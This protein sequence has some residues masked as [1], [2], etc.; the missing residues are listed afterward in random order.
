MCRA[1]LARPTRVRYQKGETY[2]NCHLSLTANWVAAGEKKS[3]QA[4]AVGKH[5]QVVWYSLSVVATCGKIDKCRK[6][7]SLRVF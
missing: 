5:E 6:T 3:G 4:I 2:V 1:R 7:L